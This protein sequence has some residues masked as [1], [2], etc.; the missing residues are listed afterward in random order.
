MKTTVRYHYT[1][2]GMSKVKKTVTSST[3]QNVEQ[4]ELSYIAREYGTITLK[5]V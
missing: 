4:L 5:T 3:G 2:T 1:P